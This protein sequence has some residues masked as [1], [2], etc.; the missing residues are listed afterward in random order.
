MQ[1]ILGTTREPELHWHS[2]KKEHLRFPEKRRQSLSLDFDQIYSCLRDFDF[3]TLL[4]G[5][6][7][8]SKP[9]SKKIVSIDDKHA[10]HEIARFVGVPVFEVIAEDG[11]IPDLKIRDVLRREISPLFP[12]S[13][14]VFI[15]GKRTQ[16][17]WHWVKRERNTSYRRE[18]FYVKG[19]P[20]DLLLDK[21]SNMVTDILPTD[22]SRV[23]KGTSEVGNRPVTHRIYQEF[24]A[25]LRQFSEYIDGISEE[26]E[27]DL[28]ASILLNRL[29]F[30]YFLQCRGFIDDGNRNYL[31]AALRRNYKD[32][33][34]RAFLLPLFFEGLSKPVQN[35]SEEMQA[36][37]GKII[38]LDGSLFQPHA[39]ELRFT[40]IQISDTAF[41]KLFSFF[42][43]YV[44][45]I[46]D[47]P[48]GEVDEITPDVLGHIFEM[49][50]NHASGVGASSTPFEIS[51]YLC[52]QTIHERILE[53]VRRLQTVHIH[54]NN[55]N[56]LE[57]ILTKLDVQLCRQLL[58]EVLPSLSVLDPACGSGTFLVAAMN[59]LITIYSEVIA[60]IAFLND[61]SLSRWLRDL[62]LRHPGL[63]YHL[64]K[65]IIT[66]NLYGVDIRD[67]A[68]EITRLRLYLA[69]LASAQSID[70]LEPLTDIGFHL[71]IGNSL[72][73]LLRANEIEDIPV[74]EIKGNERTEITSQLNRTLL[75]QLHQCS[76][77]YYPRK[78]G[79]T[80][81]QDEQETRPNIEDIERLV[82]FHWRYEFPQIMNE[83]GGF[84][85]IMTNP[86]WEVIGLS[87]RQVSETAFYQNIALQ[88]SPQYEYQNTVANGRAQRT[89]MNLYKLFV[90][91]SYN[92]LRNEGFCGI[93]VPYGI[94]FDQSAQRLRE[95]L[96]AKTRVTGLFCFENSKKVFEGLDRRVKFA[97]LT[98]EKGKHTKVFPAAFA[99]QDVAELDHFPAEETMHLTIDFVKRFS[100]DLL[101]LAEFRNR[102]DISISE[103]MLQFPFLGKRL[104]DIWN[105]EFSTGHYMGSSN[106]TSIV[107]ASPGA[108]PL[109]EGKMIHQF[110]NTFA[111]P[112]Y[113]INKQRNASF[114]RQ[115]DAQQNSG[116]CGYRL[117]FRDVA[118]GSNERTLIATV[119]PPNTLI[120]NTINF[121]SSSIDADLLLYL[122]AIFNSF[123]A[124]FFVRLRV[125]LHVTISSVYQLPVPRLTRRD[126]GF[127]AIVKRA[128]RLV[129]TT[130]EFK[131]L[132]EGAMGSPWSST[133]STTNS[134]ERNQLRAELDGLIAHLYSA[135]EEELTYILSTFPLVPNP[136]KVAVQN[137]YR[138]VERGLIS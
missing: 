59:T 137:A 124:D 43:H 78:L 38:Y 96:F 8:W 134:V 35:R 46:V 26:Q 127:L 89:G 52:R 54:R 136:A 135:M 92:L 108:L 85:V 37:L 83:R 101:A 75:Y 58:F 90:E 11:T 44:W 99:Q 103:K 114:S 7:H 120:S 9:V 48:S 125:S 39:I 84:D 42:S 40:D 91:Q 10:R 77:R 14:L 122:T 13:L 66:N 95:L 36:L 130:Q 105:I 29:I 104:D 22:E 118:S 16:S 110:T 88:C 117:G 20:E 109:Y 24:Q 138:D 6:L 82:P 25:Q 60:R 81:G 32:C 100:P 119:L 132:W 63:L 50:F 3:E 18:Y 64:K 5:E 65:G 34:Y 17:V 128:A 129:C 4:V 67:D 51:E 45:Q 56:L 102:I 72:I 12:K 80:K 70:D 61:D 126:A 111:P 116:Y 107:E 31:E 131:G 21:L 115:L 106:D 121:T 33:Y 97:L 71:S 53:K 98:F 1:S 62:R 68:I 113:W 74:S 133:V 47:V 28:Y 23:R 2:G 41:E 123:I 73:G 49:H 86:P 19:Q 112:K 76:R 69:L 93:V 27:R 57:E 55:F 30:L 87:S 79:I 94:C 15:D